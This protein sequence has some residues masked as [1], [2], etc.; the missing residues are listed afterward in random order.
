MA[1]KKPEGRNPTTEQVA[2][3]L[4]PLMLEALEELR[5]KLSRPGFEAKR[6]DAIRV[7]LEKGI[8]VLRKEPH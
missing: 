1:A 5:L 7:A 4:G 6:A 3:R 8:E 2:V